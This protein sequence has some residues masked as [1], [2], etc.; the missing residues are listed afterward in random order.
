[1]RAGIVQSDPQLGDLEGNLRRC[2]ERLDE[3]AAAGCGLVVFPECALSGY[4]FDDAESAMP[5]AI[6]VPGVETD[7]LL[8]A[9]AKHGLHCVIGVLE[10]RGETLLNT[11]LL[12]GPHGLVGAYR[13]SH[14]ACIGVDRFTEPGA[15]DYAVYDT[16]VGRIGL[17]ICYDWRFPEI[18]RVL[19][20]AG[21]EIVA[22]P[23][24]SPAAARELADYVPRTRAVENAVYFLTANRVGVEGGATFFGCSQVVDPLGSVVALADDSN[25]TLLVAE[26]DLELAREKTKEPGEGQYAVRLFADRRP[27]LY[28]ALSATK[29]R[30][31]R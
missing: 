6:D 1:M 21:A 2:L 14:I 27:E 25:E 20:L 12:L 29:P 9:C 7:V 5:A 24:N 18:T 22:H 16:P 4:M 23:T 30:R 13:K 28:G 19:A 8:A 10:R 31:R 26:L 3:A 15:D 17:Q 11:A